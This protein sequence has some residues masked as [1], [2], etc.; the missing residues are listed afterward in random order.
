VADFEW[1][2]AKAGPGCCLCNVP[3][4]EGQSYFSAL[5]QTPE[6]LN[7]Q[8]YCQSCFQER[9]PENVY[10]FWQT[11]Q[12]NADEAEGKNR[13]QRVIVDVEYVYEF[14]K[15]LE[16]DNAPQR[17]AF[18]YIL[19][20]ML[21]R[22]KWLV[23]DGKKKDS[24]GVEI[25]IFKEKRGGQSHLVLEPSLSEEEVTNVSA[26]LGVLLG[27][28]APATPQAVAQPTESAQPV[29]SAQPAATETKGTT[30]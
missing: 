4:A 6:A 12:P 26:E 27:L 1:K 11:T 15:R 30:E 22:K 28:S 5:I 13:R 3:F 8:D 21:T 24:S 7:R 16:G 29:E 25:N 23:A 17:V 9:R 2:I 20:L 10:Y 18:R 19:A 14:F